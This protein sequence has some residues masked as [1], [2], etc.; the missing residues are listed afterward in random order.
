MC[1]VLFFK[2]KICDI[3]NTNHKRPCILDMRDMKL[4]RKI[5]FQSKIDKD[6]DTYIKWVC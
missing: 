5:N 2:L 3:I 1:S 6:L 4:A